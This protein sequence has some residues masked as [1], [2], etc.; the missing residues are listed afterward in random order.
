MNRN[1]V[2]KAYTELESQ[3]I[4][5]SLP[6]K[7]CYLK[8]SSPQF[9]KQARET[10]L[11]RKIDEVVVAAHHLKVCPTDLLSLVEKRLEHLQQSAAQTKADRKETT[12]GKQ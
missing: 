4:V 7:G 3:G 5:E 10:L 6:G 1:T 12:H 8:N 9:T 2:A 11:T